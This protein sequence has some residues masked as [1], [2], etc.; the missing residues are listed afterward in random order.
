MRWA[1]GRVKGMSG[2]AGIESALLMTLALVSA[3]AAQA[4]DRPLSPAQIALFE[5]NHLKDIGHPVR[6]EYSFEH[7]GGPTGDYADVVEEDIRDIEA[8]GRKDVWIEFLTGERH[9]N[10][11]PALG[12]N[13]NP[14]LM[15]FLEHD[16]NEMREMSGGSA[17]YFRNR[18]REAFG[19]GAEMRPIEF[20]LS[21]EKHSGTEIIIAPFRHDPNIQRFPGFVDKTYHFVL[22][23]A[24]PGTLYQIRTDVPGQTSAGSVFEESM[25]YVGEKDEAQ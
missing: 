4:D 5:S 25:T 20:T 8:N 1:G 19:A 11:P 6:L 21:G 10:F 2:R 9:V 12:F 22:S 15:Y 24:V 17:Q 14:V 3:G 23:D 13:G 16:V 7:H 18:V